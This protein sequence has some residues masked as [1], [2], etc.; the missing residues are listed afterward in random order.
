MTWS[1][2]APGAV[3]VVIGLADMSFID[4]TGLT[5]LVRAYRQAEQRGPAVCARNARD[6]V[7]LVIRL[8]SF[9]AVRKGQSGLA[10]VEISQLSTLH[11][12]QL[13]QKSLSPAYLILSCQSRSGRPCRAR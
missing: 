4:A 3:R 10:A 12:P 6:E 5:V 11:H 8:T 13:G 9:T 1:I 2:E 7:D